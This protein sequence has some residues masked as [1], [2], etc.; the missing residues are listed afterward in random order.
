MLKFSEYKYE[1]LNIDQIKNDLNKLIEE[2]EKAKSAKKQYELIL[3][4]NEYRKKV[5]TICLLL[6]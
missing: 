2:L 4:I 6:V 3:K 5:E 1:E